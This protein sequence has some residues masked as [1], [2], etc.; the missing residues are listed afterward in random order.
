MIVVDCGQLLDDESRAEVL[1]LI[2]E[3]RKIQ[4]IKVFREV[5]GLGLKE[6]KEC[7][8]RLEAMG[9]QAGAQ[10]GAEATE[11]A[12]NSREMDHSSL[13]HLWTLI[14]DGKKIEAIKF[15]RQ[16]TGADLRSAKIA[17]E[18][19]E[20]G[21]VPDLAAIGRADTAGGPGSALSGPELESA[22]LG[23]C[24]QG[25]KIGAIKLYR[26]STGAGLKQAKFAV[27]DLAARHGVDPDGRPAKAE[28]YNPPPAARDMDMNAP[29]P[30]A[31]YQDHG[32]GANRHAPAD[33][34]NKRLPEPN[35]S[36]AESGGYAEPDLALE[37]KVMALIGQGRR[38]EAV[39]VHSAA[40]GSSL[41]DSAYAVET[42]EQAYQRPEYDKRC[43]IATACYGPG[44]PEVLFLREFRDSSLR[45]RRAGRM[46][47]KAYYRLSPPLAGL[48]DKSPRLRALARALIA[49]ALPA[50]GYNGPRRNP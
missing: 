18:N 19:M 16:R 6:S 33:D 8:E 48:I 3:G 9:A 38:D 36:G 14:N 15:F 22:V 25:E 11:P 41:E 12:A 27:E 26:E 5:T 24:R 21:R 39:R 20:A 7:V 50:L 45:P 10:T 4:A 47:I 35:N 43:F 31:D 49:P 2:G 29:G 40:T 37:D 1:S 32:G 13:E 42:I 34:Y 44:S 46:F 23:L 28:T 17:V 30:A